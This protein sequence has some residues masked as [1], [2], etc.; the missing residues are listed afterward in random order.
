M[1]LPV[2]SGPT[3]PN[4]K[5]T[6]PPDPHVFFGWRLFPYFKRPEHVADVLK[7]FGPRRRSTL[8][9]IV[10]A[11]DSWAINY[12][13]ATRHRPRIKAAIATK[14]IKRLESLGRAFL[15]R[16]A[17]AAEFH[18]PVFWAMI[19]MTPPSERKRRE[20][21]WEAIDPGS[22]MN[23]LLPVLQ[24]LSV[25]ENYIAVHD[26]PYETHKSLERSCLWEPLLQLME[27]YRLK[28]GQHA[29]LLRTIRSLHLALEI[30][31]PKG[32]AVR[33]MVHDLKHGHGKHQKRVQAL[34]SRRTTPNA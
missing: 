34:R 16:W 22:T 11:I 28:P 14:E 31:P 10:K 9:E 30:D 12:N 29:P 33:K 5:P 3:M 24:W 20:F 13:S 1:A 19:K 25:P 18:H 2:T 26:Q 17:D 6:E 27:E 8:Q 23:K 15:S 32:E 4:R 21:K 7:I